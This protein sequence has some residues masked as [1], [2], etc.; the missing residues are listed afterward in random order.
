MRDLMHAGHRGPRA[1]AHSFGGAGV[2]WRG[3]TLGMKREPH[4]W[5]P[6][7][8]ARRGTLRPTGGPT[9]STELKFCLM[10]L[11]TP[12]GTG[13]NKALVVMDAAYASFYCAAGTIL[14]SIDGTAPTAGAGA[15][16]TQAAADGPATPPTFRYPPAYGGQ[17]KGSAFWARQ[18]GRAATART[19]MAD[20][21]RLCSWRRDILRKC[22]GTHAGAR[23]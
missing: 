3:A 10:K 21:K 2:R 1:C 8:G 22:R 18:A 17:V 14:V 20:S 4:C 13:W 9:H 23:R 7:C 16:H 15:P 6:Q 5:L 12:A 11:S 19:A